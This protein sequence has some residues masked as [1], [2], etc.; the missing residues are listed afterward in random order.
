MDTIRVV[1]AHDH[2]VVGA[3]T[4]ILA[5]V[6]HLFVDLMPD[7]LFLEMTLADSA[8]EA[9]AHRA[10]L[11]PATP[12]VFVLRGNQNRTFVFGLL[13]DGAA[14]ALREQHAL[15]MIAEAIQA[16]AAGEGGARGHRIVANLSRPEK[17]SAPTSARDLTPR[18]VEVLRQLMTGRSDQAI[19]EHLGISRATVRYHLQHIYAKLGVR[20]RSEAIAWAARAGLRD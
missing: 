13:T 10:E 2:P 12:R 11:E 5:E 16:G 1:L 3:G 7:V 17:E 9:V 18:E 14:P 20:R 19:A 6:R 8:D 15:Q 4:H